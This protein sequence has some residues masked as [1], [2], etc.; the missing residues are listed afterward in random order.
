MNTP[1][2]NDPLAIV[3]MAFQRL[4]P[5]KTCTVEY[6]AEITDDDGERVY[7]LTTFCDDGKVYVTIDAGQAV[8]NAVETLAHEL[9]HVAVGADVEH[10]SKWEKAFDAIYEEYIKIGN[11]LMPGSRAVVVEIIGET[12]KVKDGGDDD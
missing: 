4:Y 7:G 12:V 10:G 6:D 8:C 9:A 11:E 1:F 5:D 2:K 3:W